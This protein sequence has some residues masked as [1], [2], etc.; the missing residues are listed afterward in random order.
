MALEYIVGPVLALLLGMKFTDYKT[1]EKDA[2]ITELESKIELIETETPKKLMATLD[3]CSKSSAEAQP[4]SR[5]VNVKEAKRIAF[6]TTP[7]SSLDE[8][9]GAWQWLYDN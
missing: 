4:R 5:P 6:G 3:A 9:H 2:K 1:K 8:W 7:A